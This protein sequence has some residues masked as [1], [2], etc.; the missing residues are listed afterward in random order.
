MHIKLSAKLL[1][2]GCRHDGG[3]RIFCVPAVIVSINASA[4]AY[5]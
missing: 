3:D 1:Y 5:F 2:F 4:F